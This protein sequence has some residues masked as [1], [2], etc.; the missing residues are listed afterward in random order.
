MHGEQV[1][2]AHNACGSTEDARSM[3]DD[4]KLEELMKKEKR[5]T[6]LLPMHANR[7]EVAVTRKIGRS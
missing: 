1:H 6:G 3:M 5:L 4:E 2:Q 7:M